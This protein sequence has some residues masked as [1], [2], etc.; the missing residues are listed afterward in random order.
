[1]SSSSRGLSSIV[2]VLLAVAALSC[3]RG[4]EQ[5]SGEPTPLR[6]DVRTD[7]LPGVEFVEVATS[8]DGGEPV[9]LPASFGDDYT[10][11]RRVAVLRSAP[12]RVRVELRDMRGEVVGSAE[13]DIPAE[14]SSVRLTVVRRPDA[15]CTAVPDCPRG[16]D[17][18]PAR[19]EGGQCFYPPMHGR[20]ES[21]LCHPEDGCESDV[22]DADGDDVPLTED[23]D[24][25]DPS[26]GREASRSCDDDR[27]GP[28]SGTQ[29]CTNGSWGACEASCAC[30]PGETRTETCG[31]CGT[32][33][34]VCEGGEFTTGSCV[35]EGP[36]AP[37]ATETG[38][39]CGRCGV[40]Q[41]TCSPTCGWSD[42]ICAE[43]PS[44]CWL[45]RWDRTGG[46]RGYT[47]PDAASPNAP[48]APVVAA[49]D[50]E[51]DA[52]VWLL[53][54]SSYHVLRLGDLTWVASGAL[55]AG[56][57]FPELDGTPVGAFGA[58]ALEAEGVEQ[59]IV[60]VTDGRA[61]VYDYAG[62]RRW[63]LNFV[64]RPVMDDPAWSEAGAPAWRDLRAG[65]L[66][67]GNGNGWLTAV[68]AGCST[69][70]ATA[71]YQAIVAG[72]SV[73]L[74]VPGCGF[75]E[76]PRPLASFGPFATAG[77]PDLA[78]ITAITFRE[79]TGEMWVVTP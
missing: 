76:R 43:P 39:A 24:D 3:A 14:R 53:T 1:M 46:W 58:S 49:F 55:G 40:R 34:D 42:W 79:R 41:R 48:T 7:F 78:A 21:G 32:R 56:S 4:T 28:G 68:P 69:P 17:C 26:I 65:W 15:R 38:E 57:P 12:P 18:A 73:H 66:E 74:Y 47:L 9:V 60:G 51:T 6:V 35:G 20:C 54:A 16:P 33:V 64:P 45:W 44:G 25:A 67:R 61:F 63:T 36:C 30:M 62:G 77:G 59:A 37:G 23:C 70:V 2:G 72:S 11:F 50:V 13:T 19:C 52:E 71:D 31:N 22:P 75:L 27:C 29:Q 5:P 10:T 8:G